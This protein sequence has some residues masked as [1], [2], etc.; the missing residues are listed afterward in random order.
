[1]KNYPTHPFC[2]INNPNLQH[3]KSWLTSLDERYG[4]DASMWITVKAYML[5]DYMRAH[6]LK[7]CIVAVSGGIDSAVV[8]ALAHYASEQANSPIKKIIPIFLP[9]FSNDGATGQDAALERVKEL[10]DQL[11]LPVHCVEVGSTCD[12]IINQLQSTTGLDADAWARGQSVAYTRTP[13]L[14]NLASILT[15][16]NLGSVILGTTNCDEGAYLGYVGKASDGM[17]DLQMISDLRKHEVYGVAQMLD[18]PECIMNTIPTGDMYDGRCDEEVF[19]A[20]YA[21]ARLYQYL[22]MMEQNVVKKLL[23]D[24][25]GQEKQ[26]LQN[27]F[28]NLEQLHRYNSHKYISGSPAVHLDIYPAHI[29]GGWNNKNAWNDLLS[30]PIPAHLA[31]TD[32]QSLHEMINQER[33]NLL[34]TQTN[35]QHFTVNNL[36]VIVIDN[37]LSDDFIHQFVEFSHN[38]QFIHT[39]MHGQNTNDYANGS[40]RFYVY[41]INMS[42]LLHEAALPYMQKLVERNEQYY[43]ICG[44]NPYMRFLKYSQGASLLPHYDGSFQY[45][46]S[47]K[48]LFTVLVYMSDN[49][50]GATRFIKERDDVAKEVNLFN[51]WST[52]AQ[53]TDVLLSTLPKKGRM[54]IFD[55]RLLHDSQYFSDT[56]DKCILLSEIAC[57]H[58]SVPTTASLKRELPW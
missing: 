12:T 22:L 44:V 42:H 26:L 25:S 50:S 49:D 24:V 4:V 58:I 57:Q 36:P 27:A 46:D 43:K 28:S 35:P 47:C 20:S 16:N 54:V 37:A 31:V 40:E 18:I 2:D 30:Q 21:M 32:T 29:E 56:N 51:D 8:L 55:N 5:N 53:T 23:A 13:Y 52:P 6:G 3:A 19:G 7:G 34:Y 9:A 17:V 11:D 39:D 48:N 1:M 10:C 14:Y 38:A 45:N 33:Y 41:D 15:A